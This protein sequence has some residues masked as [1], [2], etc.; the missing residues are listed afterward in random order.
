MAKK[1]STTPKKTA[2]ASKSAVGPR[3]WKAHPE[4]A[5]RLAALRW[6]AIEIERLTIEVYASDR[7]KFVEMERELRH[8]LKRLGRTRKTVQRLALGDEDCPMGYLLC[9]DGLCA[10]MCGDWMYS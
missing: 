9:K 8:T 7:T 10:P 1:K 3:L 4:D 2:K 6:F 5:I